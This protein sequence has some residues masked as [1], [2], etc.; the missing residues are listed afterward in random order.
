MAP[1]LDWGKVDWRSLQD[2]CLS[3]NS[4]RYEPSASQKPNQTTFRLPTA[5]DFEEV[6]DTLVF[7]AEGQGSWWHHDQY[8]T[9]KGVVVQMGA[10]TEWTLDTVQWLRSLILELNLQSGG[11]YELIILVEVKDADTAIFEDKGK[12]A[13]ALRVSA[14]AEFQKLVVLWTPELLQL[15]YGQATFFS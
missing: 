3:R 5:Q 1:R 7:P 9:R 6:D 13:N 14:P 8:L 15:W 10:G 4:D 12:Y 11:E 2:D